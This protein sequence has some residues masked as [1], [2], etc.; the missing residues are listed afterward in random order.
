MDHISSSDG[1][2]SDIVWKSI[3]DRQGFM[4]FATDDGLA[5][6][7]GK[8]FITLRSESGNQE[9]FESNMNFDILEDH[10][11]IIWTLTKNSLVRVDPRKM[12]ASRVN[13]KPDNFKTEITT[14]Q[15]LHSIAEDASNRLWLIT[16]YGIFILNSERKVD[17]YIMV[18]DDSLQIEFNHCNGICFD[19][20]NNAWI[21]TRA[22]IIR[23]SFQDY[24][25]KKFPFESTSDFGKA[26]VFW[27]GKI[28]AAADM[29]YAFDPET[30]TFERFESTVFSGEW[31]HHL[32]ADSSTSNKLWIAFRNE[33]LGC[34]NL[35]DSTVTLFSADENQ[36]KM[37]PG[38]VFSL[39]SDENCLWLNTGSGVYQFYTKHQFVKTIDFASTFG[40]SRENI[41]K[42]FT[43]TVSD[44]K[45]IQT[46]TGLFTW[47]NDYAGWIRHPGFRHT[48]G[49][50]VQGINFYSRDSKGAEWLSL[51]FQGV[52]KC[53][54]GTCALIVADSTVERGSRDYRW[55]M[56]DVLHDKQERAWIVAESKL[57]LS[58]NDKLTF[59][60]PPSIVNP[61]GD[62]LMAKASFGGGVL[63]GQGNIWLY[64]EFA[65]E[66]HVIAIYKFDI[67]SRTF[68]AF[69][70]EDGVSGFPEV[71]NIIS[72]TYDGTRIWCG[73]EGGVIRFDPNVFPPAYELITTKEWLPSSTCGDIVCDQSK[74]IWISTRTGLVCWIDD[75][76]VSILKK[77]DGLKRNNSGNLCLTNDNQIYLYTLTDIQYFNP[78]EI[79]VGTA[80]ANVILTSLS[81][82]SRPYSGEISP[83]YLDHIS[84]SWN[85]NNITFTFSSLQFD[86]SGSIEYAYK[87]EGAEDDW[88]YTRNVS[89][90]TYSDLNGGNYV[91]K[92]KARNQD[93]N[94]SPVVLSLPVHIDI[95]WFRSWWLYT[96]LGLLAVIAF[97]IFYKSRIQRALEIER[98]KNHI[99]TDLHD[100]V[101]SA[102]SSLILYSDMLS[103]QDLTPEKQSLLSSKITQTA[104]KSMEGMR[105][106]I[107]SLQSSEEPFS[108]S[109]AHFNRT[110]NDILDTSGKKFQL[111]T[112]GDFS[113]LNLDLEKRKNIF[114]IFKEAVNNARKYSTGNEI[115]A[116]I[117]RTEKELRM[118][119]SDNGSGFN[120][121]ASPIGN[122]LRNM[123]KRTEQSSGSFSI[124]SDLHKG[125]RIIVHFPIANHEIS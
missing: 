4:W 109:L 51:G 20:A 83:S 7:D 61:S 41:F 117:S 24:S 104:Q 89:S 44:D 32:L 73:A 18:E 85:E 90:V 74:R 120:I 123:K 59:Y 40:D 56:S 71:S 58:E 124:E 75:E 13:H 86:K 43:S 95:A 15:R 97:Y 12:N 119:I 47:D 106:I 66:N 60:T 111:N 62:T 115:T 91:F 78:N 113:K 42:F 114:L 98:V 22:G 1:L 37:I 102:L 35:E 16:T 25:I 110:A 52:Y 8:D 122:G 31:P 88:N 33:G 23:I 6:Y 67:E 2:C 9:S 26:I 10:S 29:M 57:I 105:D 19:G 34:F 3:R 64:S 99:A 39:Y 125:T 17:Q 80:I 46:S 103:A 5:R 45:I 36:Q 11:G 50:I 21:T 82:N 94:W 63:D 92:V 68:S 76:H 81:V 118:V 87:L 84:L 55:Y 101:G 79:P 100:D 70:F 53:I 49:D 96:L 65:Y 116:E 72:M 27:D 77:S 48:S 28:W 107:W 14:T 69:C 108:E 54:D 30:L 112:T 38:S 121:N 93:G